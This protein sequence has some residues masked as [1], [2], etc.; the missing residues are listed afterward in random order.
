MTNEGVACNI[1]RSWPLGL[2]RRQD[3]ANPALQGSVVDGVGLRAGW[4]SLG[5]LSPIET[6]NFTRSLYLEQSVM[7]FST[8]PIDHRDAFRRRRLVLDPRATQ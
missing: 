7:M 4:T 3:G 2:S 1:R 8:Y 5:N 6:T